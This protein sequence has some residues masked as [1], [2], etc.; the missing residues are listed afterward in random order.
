MTL[1]IGDGANDVAMIQEANVGCGL[2]G[3]EGS[4]AAMSADYAFG[5]FKFLTKLLLVHGRWSYQRIADMHSNFF[6]KNVI[7]PLAIFDAT[8]LYDYSFI[9]LYNLVFTSLPVIVLGDGLYQS[10]VVFFIP[11]LVWSLGLA[12]SWNGKGI[13]S[14]ADFGATVAVTA[15]FAASAYVGLST[16]YWTLIT[17]IVV[18]GSTLMMVL[19]ASFVDEVEVLFSNVTFWVTVVFSAL[20]ALDIVR[21]MWVLGDLKDRLGITHRKASKNK[22][23]ADL[24]TA[25][26]F[27]EPH[28]CPTSELTLA[29]A[30]EFTALPAEPE[31]SPARSANKFVARND[32]SDA[33]VQLG[34][35]DPTF[36]QVAERSGAS[37][38]SPPSPHPSYY[39]MSD[40]PIPSPVPPSLYRYPN[41][42]I[43]DKPPSRPAS[44][45]SRS[46]T[47]S[48]APPLPELSFSPASSSNLSNCKFGTSLRI[49]GRGHRAMGNIYRQIL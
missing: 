23:N 31:E 13:D 10:A 24:E 8:Y 14:L 20:V 28:A 30:Y 2:L 49:L 45:T 33:L 18:I 35:S 12:T 38:P 46:V 7:W 21:D 5:Q 34:S 16:N 17:W 9:L 1:S 42:E 3:H 26:M 19:T 41:G 44:R 47:P 11:Y 36:Q 40:I 32:T 15:I 48:S 29:H 39:S 43:T 25:P 37:P 27:R 4:Q 6:Y 22:H